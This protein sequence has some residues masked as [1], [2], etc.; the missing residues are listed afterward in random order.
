[1]T[2]SCASTPDD[3]L[4]VYGGVN[5][6]IK[7]PAK[8]MEYRDSRRSKAKRRSSMSDEREVDAKAEISNK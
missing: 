7:D 2:R 5:F 8:I 6:S 3:Q 1:M 4:V